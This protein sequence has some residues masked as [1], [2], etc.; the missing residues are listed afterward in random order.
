[1]G[2]LLTFTDFDRPV[3][4]AESEFA[5]FNPPSGQTCGEY[6]AAYLAGPGSRNNLINPDATSA[7]QVCEYS[8]GSDY[9]YTLNLKDYYYGWRDAA[10]CVL[11][12]ISSYALVFLL[13][14]VRTRASKKAE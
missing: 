10:I 13:M 6:L 14:K 11:F 12:A 4:C 3:N 5:T 9:L 7:C 8:R 1:M 2:A